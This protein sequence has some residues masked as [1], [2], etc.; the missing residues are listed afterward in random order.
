MPSNDAVPEEDHMTP[1]SMAFSDGAGLVEAFGG[2]GNIVDADGTGRGLVVRVRHA[3]KVSEHA[4]SVL[5]FVGAMIEGNRFEL[6]GPFDAMALERTL[7]GAM[8]TAETMEAAE[9]ADRGPSHA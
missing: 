8:E 4:L 2:A 6:L 7:H 5:G 3:S 9:T 1:D